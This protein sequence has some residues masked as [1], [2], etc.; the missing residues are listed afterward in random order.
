MAPVC[1]LH[2]QWNRFSFFFFQ[3]TGTSF[4]FFNVT[5]LLCF[6]LSFSLNK[7]EPNTQPEVKNQNPSKSGQ[8][9]KKIQFL[10]Q[11]PSQLSRWYH[12][13]KKKN[14][15]SQFSR[16]GDFNILEASKHFLKLIF[17]KMKAKLFLNQHHRRM[18]WL[19]WWRPYPYLS[20]E[21]T[22]FWNTKSLV[23]LL[24]LR[25]PLKEKNF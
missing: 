14:T 24:L 21:T 25:F 9:W 7:T 10:V 22:S 23:C 20:R 16:L 1:S 15:S 5:G 2:F 13:V 4:F 3:E 19:N 18:H 12:L 6:F 8:K 11:S 17:N